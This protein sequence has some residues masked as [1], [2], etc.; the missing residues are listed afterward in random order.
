M[1]SYQEEYLANNMMLLVMRLRLIQIAL[2]P[3]KRALA[4][5]FSID[6]ALP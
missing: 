6:S 1:Q 3:S 5:V 4:M 2:A